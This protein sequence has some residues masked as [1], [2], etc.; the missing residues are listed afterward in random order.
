MHV[1]YFLSLLVLPMHTA[2][3]RQIVVNDPT[4]APWARHAVTELS[5]DG[6]LR[7]AEGERFHGS[8]TALRAHVFLV[9]ARLA[10]RLSLEK[11]PRQD[12]IAR[13]LGLF[14][15]A[16]AEPTYDMFKD[17]EAPCFGEQFADVL[18]RLDLVRASPDGYLRVKR[19]LT[20]GQLAVLVARVLARLPGH[21]DMD[22]SR[23][24]FRDADGD[25]W[26]FGSALVAA[27]TGVMSRDADGGFHADRPV[28]R[29]E[30]AVCLFRLLTLADGRRS[31]PEANR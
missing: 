3:D 24:S 27:G 11:T 20:R 9:V 25:E 23:S 2:A 29:N 19:P 7:G 22:M 12:R 10:R 17:Y 6:L 16:P 1:A 13:L 21:V 26:W 14:A 15:P 31:Q 18:Q 30:L 8:R 5:R 28:T 4:V